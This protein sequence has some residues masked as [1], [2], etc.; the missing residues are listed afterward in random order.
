VT[1]RE[2]IG[3]LSM[4]AGVIVGY[5]VSQTL[6]YGGLLSLISGVIVGALFAFLADQLYVRAKTKRR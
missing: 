3:T 2:G 6:G 4:M 1:N 5:Y